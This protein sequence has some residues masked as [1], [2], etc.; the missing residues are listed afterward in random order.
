MK[1]ILKGIL[2]LL[3]LISL[4]MSAVSCDD[5]V[6]ENGNIKYSEY[7][8][9][10]RL[11]EEMDKKTVSYAAIL[12][13]NREATF[14]VSYLDSEGFTEEEIDPDIKIDRYAD[15]FLRFND[16][17][18]VTYNYDEEQRKVDFFAEKTFDEGKETE[19]TVLYYH[20]LIR[21]DYVIYIVTMYCDVSLSEKYRPIFEEWGSYIYV[22]N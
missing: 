12:H 14:M 5:G 3:T 7:G 8:F 21:N 9:N 4:I 19:E 11:P 6:D 17:D 13:S 20:I 10:Y 16:Y 2:L 18:G 1:K 15:K 22:Q